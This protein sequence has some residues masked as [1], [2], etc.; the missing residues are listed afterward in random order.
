MANESSSNEDGIASFEYNPIDKRIKQGLL[1][2][3]SR[4]IEDLGNSLLTHFSGREVKMIDIYKEHSVDTPFIKKNYK[5]IL[6]SLE[7]ENKIIAIRRQGQS[8]NNFADD[9]IARFPRIY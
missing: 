2:K 7:K 4:P 1:F 6:L 8:K 5:E 3:L 9:V